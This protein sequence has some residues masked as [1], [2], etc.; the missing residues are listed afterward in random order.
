MTKVCAYTNAISVNDIDGFSEFGVWKSFEVGLP[1]V[2][3]KETTRGYVREI[4]RGQQRF[5]NVG[6]GVDDPAWGAILVPA[7]QGSPPVLREVP[8]LFPPDKVLCLSYVRCQSCSRQTRFSASP[9]W[10][11][12]LVPARQGSPS[13]QAFRQRR[14][15][16]TRL[17]RV[18]R[19]LCRGQGQVGITSLHNTFVRRQEKRV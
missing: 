10:G 5:P 14:Q 18:C 6:R 13:A 9:A 7:R 12:I 3:Q 2:L 8:F 4:R 16:K 1:R 17:P 19:L 11:A 15:R